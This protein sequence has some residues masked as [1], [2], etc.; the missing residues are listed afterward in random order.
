MSDL[1]SVCVET[2]GT[3]VNHRVSTNRFTDVFSKKIRLTPSAKTVLEKRYLKKNSDGSVGEKP[4]E[5]FKRVAY[6]IAEAD[7]VFDPDAN[8]DK[9]AATFYEMMIERDFIPNS[10]TLMN[11]GH[12]LGQLSACFVLP[13]EDSIESIFEAVKHTALIH[14]SGGGTGFS[15]SKLR[16]KNDTV[17]TTAGISSGPVSFMKVFDSAT[18]AIKQGGRRRGANMGILRIDH[19]DIIEFIGAKRDLSV[20]TNFN[21]SVAITEEFMRAVKEEREYDLINPREGNSTQK[22]NAREVFDLIV[23]CAWESGE[24]GIIFIDRINKDNPTPHV[25]EIESTNPCVTGDTWVTTTDGPKQVKALCGKPANILLDGEFFDTGKKGFFSTG[26][27]PVFKIKTNR[28]YEIHATD[29]HL[30]RTVKLIT[31]YRL[32]SEWREVNELETGD[33]I[34]LSNNRG[35]EW[36]GTGT[37]EEGYLLGLLLGDGT[38]KKDD[39]IISVWGDSDGAQSIREFALICAGKFPHRSDF[40]GFSRV[41][42]RDE[43]RMKLRALKKL[44]LKFGMKQ[45]NKHITTAIEETSS[46]FHRGFLRGLF[47]ADG[48]VQGTQEKG[49]SLRLWQHNLDDLKGVQRMLHRLGIASTI[50]ERR[51]PKTEKLMPD[52]KGGKKKYS[53]SEGHELVISNDNLAVFAEEIAFADVDKQSAL[54]GRLMLYQREY[55]RERFIAEIIEISDEG[56]RKVYDVNIPGTNAFDANGFF[57]HNCGEQPLLPYESCN[58][59]S[60]NLSNFITSRGKVDWNKLEKTV[61]NAVHFLDNVI[62]VNKFPIE[63]IKENTRA[64]RKIGLGI[65]GFAEMLFKLRISYC[66]DKAITL[67]EEVMSFIQRKGHEASKDFAGLRGAFPNFEGSLYSKSDGQPRRHATITT[68]APTGSISI[69]AG[70]SSGIEPLF[71]LAFERNVLDGEKL[72]DINQVFLNEL[73]ERGLY[74]DDLVEKIIGKGTIHDIEEIPDDMK[75]IYVVAHDVSPEW[76]IRSQAAFQKYTDNAVSKTINFPNTATKEDIYKGYMLSYETG[77]KGVTVYRDGCRAMQVLTMGANGKE[78][79]ELEPDDTQLQRTERHV[80]NRPHAVHGMT[81]KVATGCGNLYSTINEDEYGPFEV[82]AHLGKTGGCAASQSEALSRIISLALRS[83]VPAEEVIK[84]LKG[85]RCPNPIWDRGDMILSCP[86]GVAKA[87][88]WGLEYREKQ[89]GQ[90]FPSEETKIEQHLVESKSEIQNFPEMEK[91]KRSPVILCPECGS[92]MYKSEGCATCPACGF[93]KCS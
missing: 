62:E 60:I 20:L 18:E 32:E 36:S 93:S 66:S 47:D 67:A 69:I 11:A 74:S 85:I 39:A 81:F 61:H 77:C 4:E 12:H 28:G 5:L 15:F 92:T 14:K 82:F 38:L 40:K 22:L 23:E 34:L 64:N 46:L 86:D 71:A 45:R 51:T 76:H 37:L 2:S 13:I 30:I 33:F 56:K 55:N 78:E 6:A 72:V 3:G 63:E 21:I 7:T 27:K 26:V 49:V 89:H 48:S 57:V 58:L 87:L 8:I 54:L 65:M 35:A 73:T 88:E 17:H 68:I 25:G 24:P 59:G 52:G 10:P 91:K 79:Q 84:Q 29:D 80:R 50:Y 42:G 41:R 43:Y 1:Q 19:P 70:T 83:G 9:V 31:R 44:A 53:V 16:P 90:L 75:E